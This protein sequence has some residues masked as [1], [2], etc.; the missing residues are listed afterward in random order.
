[1]TEKPLIIQ[2]DLTVLVDVSSPR[3]ADARDAL[4]RF[5]ELVKSPEHI[6]TYRISP[7]SVWNACAAG[8]A[9]GDIVET[10][11]DYARYP[12]PVHVATQ[13]RDFAD[14]FGRVRIERDESDPAARHLLMRTNDPLLAEELSRGRQL[15]PMLADR[16]SPTVF[17]I[18]HA[19]RG[20][21]KQALVKA[22]FPAEDIAG[23]AAGESL[24]IALR[25]CTRSGAPFA[26]R[27]YQR[28]AATAFH[29][30]GSERGGSGV[31]VL[32]CGAGKT[33]VGMEVMAMLHASTLILTTSVT[34]VRQWIAELLDKTT[35]TEDSIGEYSAHNKNVRPVT[36]ATYQILTHRARGRR[37]HTP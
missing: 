13:V 6:H 21:I 3:Y 24:D 18:H 4:A 14:R 15:A 31:I 35:L 26:L 33:V 37:V 9:V 29:A 7:L 12:M 30:R 1:M 8:V 32:P 34:A 28:D 25:P 22:G 2:S 5:A 23:Y 16:V 11:V 19:D 36:V 10:L 27:E 20:R 17:R